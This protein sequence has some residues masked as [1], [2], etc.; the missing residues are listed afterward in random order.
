MRLMLYDRTCTG[1]Q[2]PVGL[3][4]AW[5]V[6][7]P[8]YRS[9][10]RIDAWHGASSWEEGL[11]WLAHVGTDAPI[12]EIQFW[13]HGR[14]GRAL[15]D[16]QALTTAALSPGH[17]AYP[18]LQRISSRMEPNGQWWFRTC[19]TLGAHA[20]HDFAQ[21]WSDFMGC[22]VAGYTFVI[23]V[24]QSGLHRLRPGERPHWSLWEGIRRGRPEA[25]EKAYGSGPTRP[26]TISFLDGRVPTGW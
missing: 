13:G 10:G 11:D 20:G 24:W 8:L 2:W 18:L 12:E 9:W 5:R 7:G 3:T 25:P 21:R 6:G 4:H 15:I 16:G 22:A 23:G 1:G 19:E 26:H 14:W 17:A